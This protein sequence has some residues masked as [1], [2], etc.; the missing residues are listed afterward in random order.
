MKTD[1]KDQG[2]QVKDHDWLLEQGSIKSPV[3]PI[4]TSN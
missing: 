1:E 3:F 2:V 4:A